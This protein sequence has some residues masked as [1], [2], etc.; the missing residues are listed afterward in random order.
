MAAHAGLG[1]GASDLVPMARQRD[2]VVVA[3]HTI[4]HV[5]ENGGQIQLRRQRP[6][7]VGKICHRPGEMRIPLRRILFSGNAFAP[8]RVETFASRRSFTNLSL[9]ANRPKSNRFPVPVALARAGSA[10]LLRVALPD[11]LRLVVAP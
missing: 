3:D 7:L 2:R 11:S 8:S 9:A 5:T 1:L 6:M 10:D 4:L